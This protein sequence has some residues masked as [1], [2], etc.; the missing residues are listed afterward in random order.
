MSDSF[1]GEDGDRFD[2]TLISGGGPGP[3]E[4]PDESDIVQSPLPDLGEED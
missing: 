4:L 1:F 3:D 2:F